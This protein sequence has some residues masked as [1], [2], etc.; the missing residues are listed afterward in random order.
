MGIMMKKFLKVIIGGYALPLFSTIS[1]TTNANSSNAI[2][3]M[4][5]FITRIS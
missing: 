4:T 5:D 1:I 3:K 2:G